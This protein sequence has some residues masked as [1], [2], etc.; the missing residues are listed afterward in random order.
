MEE[1]VME[2]ICQYSLARCEYLWVNEFYLD[3]RFIEQVDSVGT[4]LATRITER[5]V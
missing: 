4:E 5:T 2:V 3:I 1:N